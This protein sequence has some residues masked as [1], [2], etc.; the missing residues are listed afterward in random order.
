MNTQS[1]VIYRGPSMLD[2]GPIVAIAT[3]GSRNAKTG[4]MVQ[5]WIMRDDVKP[6]AAAQSG[7][8][9]S[10]CGDC[11]HRPIVGGACY[12]NLGQGPRAVW[13][14]FQRGRY[15]DAADLDDGRARDALRAIGAGRVV[16][17]GSYGDPAAVPLG[18][19]IELTAHATAWTGYTHQW[20]HLDAQKLKGL[21]MASTD[22]P[23]E[24]L[25]AHA[26]GWRTFR[27]RTGDESLLGE[28]ANGRREIACPAS[29]EMG[30]K[31]DC[32]SCQ[33]CGGLGARALVNLAIVAHGSKARRF[34]LTRNGAP[35]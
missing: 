35:A 26:M 29:D 27:V 33:A 24:T 13:E 23:D 30:N 28:H 17:L 20:R 22:T 11:K 2:G 9:A 1:M 34:A 19:W 31:T 8:D 18:V 15:P 6:L 32:A 12:V 21:C 3:V 5:T 16:R 25:A 14:A 10:V 7:A 4:D